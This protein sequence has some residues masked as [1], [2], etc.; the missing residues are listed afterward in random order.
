MSDDQQPRAPVISAG[1]HSAELI[2]AFLS[3]RD[4]AQGKARQCVIEFAIKDGQGAGMRISWFG[5]FVSDKSRAY[6]VSQLRSLGWT[7]DPSLAAS[8]TGLSKFTFPKK[9]ISLVITHELRAAKPATPTL[10]AK[11]ATIQAVVKYINTDGG[12]GF[13]ERSALKGQAE[14]SASEDLASLFAKDATIAGEAP[15]AGAQ[16]FGDGVPEGEKPDLPF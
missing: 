2:Q 8:W 11:P 14:I 10:P 6:C 5:S 15:A 13:A 1:Q 3:E 12:G 7:A 16:G 4:T 9:P